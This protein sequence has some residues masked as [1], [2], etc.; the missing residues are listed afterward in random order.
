M[1]AKTLFVYNFAGWMVLVTFLSVMLG[2]WYSEIRR[3]KA[4]W[5]PIMC[6]VSWLAVA[7]WFLYVWVL[8]NMLIS[9]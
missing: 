3:F 8:N 4:P 6:R 9:I 7:S 1:T 5:R 2:M